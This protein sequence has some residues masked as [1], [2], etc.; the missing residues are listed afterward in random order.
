MYSKFSRLEPEKKERIINAAIKE[1]ARSGYDRASTNEIIKEANISK[2]S[3]FSYFNNKKDLYIFLLDYIIDFIDTIY[4]KIDWNE[5]DIFKRLKQLALIK[6]KI[7]REYPQVFDFLQ[8]IAQEN[9]PEVTF[10]I[11]KRMKK[12]VLP[13]NGSER[14]YRNTD[15]TKF[16]DDIDIQKALHIIHWTALSFAEQLSNKVHSFEDFDI[17]QLSEWESYLDLLKRCFYKREENA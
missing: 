8:A 12:F 3:L 9:A 11:E 6:F 4:D 7:Y 5:T 15:V 17:G 13:D 16:R 2:G 1:F 10:E 14:M